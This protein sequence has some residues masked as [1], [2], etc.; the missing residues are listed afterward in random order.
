MIMIIIMTI[1]IIIISFVDMGICVCSCTKV[2][3]ARQR[4][5]KIMV[6]DSYEEMKR[7]HQTRIRNKLVQCVLII[8]KW[9]IMQNS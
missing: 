1:L 8:G 4:K 9:P 2:Q 6:I 5:C 3:P 7:Y